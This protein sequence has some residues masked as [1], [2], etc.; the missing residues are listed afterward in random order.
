MVLLR[1]C[2]GVFSLDVWFDDNKDESVWREALVM[3]G[4]KE[5]RA[6]SS[7]STLDQALRRERAGGRS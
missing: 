4:T 7:C 3:D 6:L 2:N 5:A 1:K